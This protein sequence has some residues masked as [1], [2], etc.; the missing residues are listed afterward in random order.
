MQLA[1]LAVV[2]CA[3]SGAGSE[4]APPGGIG[5]RLLASLA[6]LAAAPLAALAFPRAAR[7]SLPGGKSPGGLQRRLADW[8]W[9]VTCVW[10]GGCLAVLYVARL[11]EIV[12]SISFTLTWPLVDDLL[13]L[14]P[15]LASL[16]LV[17]I[18]S[19]RIERT[20]D[21][22]EAPHEVSLLKY[23]ELRWRHHLGL[24]LLPALIILG[25]Q[26]SAAAMQLT[27]GADDHRAWW[28]WGILVAAA[29]FA[30]PLLLRWIWQT[31]RVVDSPLKQ[32]LLE[33]CRRIGC[34]VRDIVIWRTGGT[35]AN[36]AV[37]GLLPG[38]RTIFLSDGLIQRLSDDEIDI[39]VRHEAAHLAQ[40]HLW[41]RLALLLVPLALYAI[42]Q[43]HWPQ[44]IASLQE[45]LTALGVAPA[46]QTSLL[47]PA[48]ALAYAM[49]AVGWLARM[50][51]HDADLAA[52]CVP[53]RQESQ[54][55]TLSGELAIDSRAVE[56]L[57]SALCKLVGE[58]H[59]YDRRRWFHPSVI[60][61]VDFLLGI[62]RQPLL[63]PRF[64][65]RLLRVFWG[66]LAA[67][68]AAIVAGLWPV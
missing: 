53:A 16:N 10:T 65:A 12:R 19:H 32:R 20:L 31:Q 9:L 27:R 13:I 1:I 54:S 58:S 29:I 44:A 4:A 64:R 62:C 49:F 36:A 28:L 25:L 17:W 46:M 35:V 38:W 34:P 59:E 51:E 45:Q 47:L 42:V 7:G 37:A 22:V 18:A 50:H 24:T 55:R 8:Q 5:W 66:L 57:H 14:A 26:E 60:E 52:C 43:A 11:P 23:L 30:L 68:L 63:A 2:V 41:Q 21:P 40:R 39:V 15:L 61:R 56:H 6:F 48:A 67:C 3:I 33:S